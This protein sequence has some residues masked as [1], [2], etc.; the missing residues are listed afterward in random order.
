MESVSLSYCMLGNFS[1]FLSSADFFSK[2]SEC[3]TVCNWTLIGPDD[4]SGIIW[5]QTVCQA[6]DT[7]RQRGKIAISTSEGSS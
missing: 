5:V 4:L 7:G 2:S 6:Y 1:C 3:Q